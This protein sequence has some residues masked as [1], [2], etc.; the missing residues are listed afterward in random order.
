[1]EIPN[2]L[3]MQ[4]GL[5]IEEANMHRWELAKKMAFW[6]PKF[7]TLDELKLY[8]GEKQQTDDLVILIIAQRL[9]DAANGVIPPNQEEEKK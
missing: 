4:W 3:L 7:E 9:K 8:L 6:I 5:Q 2:E 1:M